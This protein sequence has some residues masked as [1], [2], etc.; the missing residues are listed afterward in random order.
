MPC[1][2]IQRLEHMFAFVFNV[3][4][5][6]FRV[7]VRAR[8]PPFVAGIDFDE[9]SFGGVFVPE[10]QRLIQHHRFDSVERDVV[11]GS[12]KPLLRE[13]FRYARQPVQQRSHYAVVTAILT[14]LLSAT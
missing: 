14:H 11:I 9:K 7:L 2:P 1:L 12:R 10:K 4:R 6:E 13:R 5:F 3:G 8:S